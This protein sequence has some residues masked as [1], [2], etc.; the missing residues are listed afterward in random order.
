[1]TLA[2]IETDERERTSLPV[3]LPSLFSFLAPPSNGLLTSVPALLIDCCLS[4][5]D[6][7]I[8]KSIR[9]FRGQHDERDGR[10]RDARK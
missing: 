4:V 1:M 7:L 6:S 9:A 8:E 3:S 2:T 10:E 5:G